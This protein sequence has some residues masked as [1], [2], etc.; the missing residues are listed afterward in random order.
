MVRNPFWVVR[1]NIQ[2]SVLRLW[3]KRFWICVYKKTNMVLFWSVWC[4]L[5]IKRLTM[6]ELYFFRDVSNYEELKKKTYN[7][8]RIKSK[9]KRKVKI[10]KKIKLE[11]KNADDYLKSIKSDNQHVINNLKIMKKKKGIWYC[12]EFVTNDKSIVV[13]ADGYPY[14]KYTAIRFE[15]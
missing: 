12:I 4:K 6:L 13:M 1:G 8:Y 15:N 2:M 7:A 5:G 14:A 3:K 11:E 9:I 10:V